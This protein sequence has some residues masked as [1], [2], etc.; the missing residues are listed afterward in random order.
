MVLSRP[1]GAFPSLDY[2][3]FRGGAEVAARRHRPQRPPRQPARHRGADGCRSHRCRP[4]EP[5]RVLI[6]QSEGGD[7]EATISARSGD[8]KASA[9]VKV[10]K[11]G[12]PFSWSFRNH[13]L[14]VLTKIGCNSGA[15]HGALAGKGGF[16]LSL[17]GYAPT[18][19]YFVLT[20]QVRG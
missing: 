9:S 6:L 15:C 16:K 7:R 2:A 12:E 4:D 19:D 14:P 8:L 5:E 10:L 11:T 3:S 20:R 1:P 18:D 17:R 13:V